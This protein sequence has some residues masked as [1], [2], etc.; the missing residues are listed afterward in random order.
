MQGPANPGSLRGSILRIR[1]KEEGGYTIPKGNLWETAAAYFDSKGNAAVAAKYRDSTKARREVYVKGVRNPYTLSLDPVRR[2][3]AWGDCGP[4]QENGGTPDSTLWTE[5][6]NIATAP[7]FYGWP[8]W[9]AL[10][11]VQKVKPYSSEAT[12]NAAW[13]DWS[14]LNPEA[15]VN[16]FPGVGVPELTPAIKGT[17]SYGHSCAM[18]GPIYRY[19]GALKSSV[20]MPPSFNRMWLVTDF[21]K[22]TIKAVKIND[23]AKVAAA[24]VELFKNLSPNLI[25]PLDFQQGPDGAL[26]YLNYSCGVW[27]TA[28]A[29]TGIYR[30]EYKGTC[31]DEK[32][33]PEVAT[34]LDRNPIAREARGPRVAI[35][36]GRIAVGVAGGYALALHDMNG[37]A[38][39]SFS[40]E[41]EREYKAA[42]LLAGAQPGVYFV[43]VESAEGVF[44]GSVSYFP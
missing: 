20:K 37:K 18:T 23:A 39:R 19:D 32:V 13:A 15:P 22:G 4:D 14:T 17:H 2:W 40:S 3:A 9:S 21:N 8:Y 43:K 7:G 11:H 31:H 35:A 16:T 10:N 44:T 41:G 6:H 36:S 25:R 29:C 30:I 1:P 26:Y 27:Y 12:E 5:E 34:A 33:R 24:D 38:V 42:D 28:D